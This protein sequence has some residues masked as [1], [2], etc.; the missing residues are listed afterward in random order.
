MVQFDNQS[1]Q[2]KLK[3]VY[4][5]PALGGKTTSLQYIHRAVDP[6]RR[7]QLYSLNTSNDR[8]LFFDLLSLDLGVIRGHKL[9][10]QLYTVP[11][12]VQYDATR[13]VVLSGVDAVVFVADAQ[14]NQ[15]QANIQSRKNLEENLVANK[16]DPATIPLVF[17]LNKQ[18]LSPLTPATELN[19][20]IN[21]QGAPVFLTTATSGRDV[22]ETFAA[23]SKS[24]VAG[25]GKRLGIDGDEKALHRLQE[26]VRKA[27][28]PFID[29]D[30][31]A[32]TEMAS[33]PNE[34]VEIQTLL[35]SDQPLEEIELMQEAVHANLA[36]T[37]L[38]SQL[39][40]TRRRLE[41]TIEALGSIS[42]FGRKLS[43][44][45]NPRDILQ[46]LLEAAC[47]HLYAQGGAIML[48]SAGS[49]RE[50]KVKFLIQDP[51][52]SEVSPSGSSLADQMVKEKSPMLIT[53]DPTRLQQ[54][55]VEKVIEAADCISAIVI[56]LVAQD[57]LLGLLTLYRDHDRLSFDDEDLQLATTM[58]L[59]TSAAYSNA[60]NWLKLQK[61]N[62][63]LET[64]VAERTRDLESSLSEVKVLN[65]DL[66]EKHHAL[67]Q[68]FTDLEEMGRLKGELLARV[69]HELRTPVSSL[70]TAAVIL[71][72]DEPPPPEVGAR[73]VK[74]IRTEAERL[75]EI[76]EG[77]V[78]AAILAAAAEAPIR[79]DTDMNELIDSALEPLRPSALKREVD[80]RLD[81]Q[82]GLPKIPSDPE[83]LTTA[84]QAITKN[85][86]DFNETRGSVDIKVSRNP[87]KNDEIA[88]KIRDSGT[89]IPPD[90]L[91]LV[92]DAFWQGGNIMTGKPP[93]IGLGLTI[94]KRVAENHGGSLSIFSD[95]GAGTEVVF[96]LPG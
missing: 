30:R 39:D 5:G 32:S 17:Q 6:T 70:L 27:L 60:A 56:P 64:Q 34:A 2:I 69:S 9:T 67:K 68:A 51:L 90:D 61:T 24:A 66:S 72:D 29:A 95:A 87:D 73:F 10:L 18:D 1:R 19:R 31:Q 92:F 94:A 28:T 89:G 86:I 47:K 36:M 22:M 40:T 75:S 48:F 20:L 44:L 43:T 46:N 16:I 88:I 65:T 38:N 15:L 58:A 53:L 26:Q 81:V 55:H 8:T 57:F 3:I 12:Q 13:R 41:H 84:V 11:G 93:G 49:L 33:E 82:S 78:Q 35:P 62:Q 14:K 45:R 21:P 50:F 77:V 83:S 79:S 71:A 96:S 52:L 54:T 37:D 74:I 25:A 76:I 80:I 91:P 42:Q 23:I 4:Y 63:N 7:T 59:N 85:A